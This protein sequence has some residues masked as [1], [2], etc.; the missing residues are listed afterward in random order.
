M[1]KIAFHSK[2]NQPRGGFIAPVTLTLTQWP[3]RKKT[4]WIF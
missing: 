2:A 3:W 1:N 4:S